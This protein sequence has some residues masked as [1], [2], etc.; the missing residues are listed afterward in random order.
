[1]EQLILDVISKQVEKKKVIRNSQQRFP[2]ENSCLTN[3]IALYDVITGWVD[4]GRAL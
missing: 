3:Q 1:M 2:K 4:E